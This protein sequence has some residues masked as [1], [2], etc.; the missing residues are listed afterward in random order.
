[1]C[2][3]LDTP[4]I[5]LLNRAISSL[6]LNTPQIGVAQERA[7]EFL[8]RLEG[9]L[10]RVSNPGGHR[11]VTSVLV[12][13]DQI[14]PSGPGSMIRNEV[15]LVEQYVTIPD[16]LGN[17]SAVLEQSVEIEECPDEE[18]T[19][20][21][22][23]VPEDIGRHDL[24]LLLAALRRLSQG[25]TPA[26]IVTDDL[27]LVNATNGLAAGHRRVTLDATD[28]STR[29]LTGQL[30]LEAFRELHRACAIDNQLWARLTL[31]YKEHHNGRVGPSAQEHVRR[32]VQFLGQ[33]Q[34]DCAEK[35]KLR[36]TREL[37]QYFLGDEHAQ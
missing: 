26:I 1:M 24:S 20:L 2:M 36:I 17:W 32:A 4:C 16:F 8:D 21:R 7:P 11:A 31:S 35:E 23:F 12:Y 10:A 5:N 30:S 33:Y 22:G 13:N 37:E 18:L 28:Y 19:D 14:E 29:G 3:I 25:D 9:F 6:I 34:Y 15:E 27:K